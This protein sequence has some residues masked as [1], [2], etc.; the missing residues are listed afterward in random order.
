[1]V[2]WGKDCTNGMNLRY[3]KKDK[4]FF[5]SSSAV[6]RVLTNHFIDLNIWFVGTRT[7]ALGPSPEVGKKA[8]N[9]KEL[10]LSWPFQLVL[11]E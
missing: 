3:K 2:D 10:N 4:N 11:H 5:F 7:M 8:R 1:M 6:V 9:Y